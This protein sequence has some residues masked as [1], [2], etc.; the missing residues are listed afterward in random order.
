MSKFAWPEDK[1]FSPLNLKLI[2]EATEPTL[3]LPEPS[4][5]PVPRQTKNTR[6][7]VVALMTGV[8]NHQPRAIESVEALEIETAEDQLTESMRY[9]GG[10]VEGRAVGE[11]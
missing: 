9:R 3:P 5:P 6:T 11:L 1:S 8:E 4:K 2:E 7:N 10:R